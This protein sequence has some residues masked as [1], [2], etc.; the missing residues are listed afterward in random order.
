MNASEDRSGP[1]S[2]LLR[3]PLNVRFAHESGRIAD[4]GGCLKC[5]KT[6]CEQSQQPAQLFDHLVGAGEQYRW[7]VDA[8]RL[9]GLQVDD[10]IELGGPQDRQVG[11]L[12][13]L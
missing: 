4:I 2:A 1:D 13:A 10:E 5:A 6:S 8:E 9:G 11:R 7:N 12:S 3:C